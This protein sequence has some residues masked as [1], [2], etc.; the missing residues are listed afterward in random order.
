MDAPIALDIRVAVCQSN[1]ER[2]GAAVP[3]A[4][5]ILLIFGALMLIF[6]GRK[7]PEMVRNM[8]EARRAFDEEAPDSVKESAKSKREEATQNWAEARKAFD[9]EAPDSV[10]GSMKSKRDEAAK[11]WAEARRAYET[12]RDRPSSS[13]DDDTPSEE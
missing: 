9:E 8:A 13:H 6:G 11:N 5:E 12:E 3:S 2:G 1:D 4:L 10:K 7:L